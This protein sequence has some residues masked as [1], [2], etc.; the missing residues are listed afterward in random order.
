MKSP[1]QQKFQT[2]ALFKGAH[3]FEFNK[4]VSCR[5]QVS[6]FKLKNRK[7]SCKERLGMNMKISNTN[8]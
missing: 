5:D 6:Y 8:Y 3:L 4:N 7:I 1:Q 2:T